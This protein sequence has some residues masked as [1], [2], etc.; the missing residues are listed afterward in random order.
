MTTTAQSVFFIMFILALL[1][2]HLLAQ[3]LSEPV[4]L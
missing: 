3:S 1:F 4:D 2:R